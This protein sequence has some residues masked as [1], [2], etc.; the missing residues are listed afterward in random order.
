MLLPLEAGME[1]ARQNLEDTPEHYKKPGRMI[2]AHDS[3]NYYNS[4]SEVVNDSY[5]VFLEIASLK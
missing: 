5:G 4:S 2:D 3:E 1:T